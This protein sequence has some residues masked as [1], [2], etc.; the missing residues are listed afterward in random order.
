MVR[1]V[2]VIGHGTNLLPHFIK[3]YKQ[4]VD[5]INI[6]VYESD[7]HP[8]LGDEVKKIVENYDNVNIVKVHKDRLFDWE[9]VTMLYNYV[10]NRKP[11]DWWVVADIDE[12]HLYPNDDLGKLI[13][14]CDNRGYDIVRGGFIDRIGRG[15]EFTELVDDTLIWEQFPN[16]GFFRY[17][18][19]GANPNKI[20]VMKG[21]IEL[22]SGQH[23]AN[24]NG[25]TTW[26]WQGWNHPLISQDN[27]VQVHHFKWDK[28]SIDRIKAVAGINQKY[29]YSDEYSKMFIELNKSKFKINL[30]KSDYMFELGTIRPEYNLYKKWNKLINKIKSI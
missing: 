9:R 12:F 23:Y 16:A 15:G 13:S 25:N 5:E 18:M 21:Y 29:A 20:C 24:I 17:P 14:D 10:T 30:D 4:Y 2:T 8:S 3:H 6:V 19:S 26:R 7:I 22:T 1:L 11:N 28:T 27:T